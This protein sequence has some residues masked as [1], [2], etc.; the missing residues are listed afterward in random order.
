M[1]DPE[2]GHEITV[3]IALDLFHDNKSLNESEQSVSN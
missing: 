1:Q 2:L 3:F